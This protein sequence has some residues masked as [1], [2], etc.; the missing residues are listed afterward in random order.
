MFIA[1]VFKKVWLFVKIL[2]SYLAFQVIP[3]LLYF[4]QKYLYKLLGLGIYVCVLL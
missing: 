4:F 3:D 1:F 2:H